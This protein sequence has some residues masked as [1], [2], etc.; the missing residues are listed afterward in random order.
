[1]MDRY[2]FALPEKGANTSNGNAF[3]RPRSGDRPNTLTIS[4]NARSPNLNLEPDELQASRPDSFV[5][6]TTKTIAQQLRR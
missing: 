1:M 5:E 3:V 6:S 2:E 4:R